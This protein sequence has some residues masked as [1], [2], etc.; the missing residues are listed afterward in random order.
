MKMLKQTTLAAAVLAVALMSGCAT[1]RVTHVTDHKD[2]LYLTTQ[3]KTTI[4]YVFVLKSEQSISK[5][6][7]KGDSQLDCREL[8]VT[9]NGSD[10]VQ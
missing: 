4:F 7:V 9:F 2:E 6:Q 5:C 8:N 10:W 3:K 1:Y